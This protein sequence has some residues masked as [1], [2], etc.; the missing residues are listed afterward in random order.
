MKNRAKKALLEEIK[1]SFAVG[2][3]DL[4]ST[5]L[6][7]DFCLTDLKRWEIKIVFDPNY[8]NF[9]PAENRHLVSD[10][11][12]FFACH[13]CID[14]HKMQPSQ[15]RA[16]ATFEGQAEALKILFTGES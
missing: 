12:Q 6:W 13:N 7:C 4:A 1:I 5:R 10:D 2:S 9:L 16:A 3:K 8:K 15:S 11:Q 14:K